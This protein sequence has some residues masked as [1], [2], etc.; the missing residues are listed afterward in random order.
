VGGMFVDFNEPRGLYIFTVDSVEE[1][2]ALVQNEP[3]IVAGKVVFEFHPWR[4]PELRITLP[5][6]L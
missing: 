1:A 5:D 6:E 3:N 4:A 2:Q